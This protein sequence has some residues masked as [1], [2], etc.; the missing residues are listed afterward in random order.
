MRQSHGSAFVY[1]ICVRYQLEIFQE[2]DNQDM[3]K[4]IEVLC[5]HLPC[6]ALRHFGSVQ[7]VS[8]KTYNLER[9]HFFYFSIDSRHSWLIFKILKNVFLSLQCY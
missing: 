6:L 5:D 8:Q 2:F 1:T 4:E 7:G 3:I 9:A